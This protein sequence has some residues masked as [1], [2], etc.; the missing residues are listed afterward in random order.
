M[1]GCA[2]RLLLPVAP[3]D[4]AKRFRLRAG[5]TGQLLGV[6]FRGCRIRLLPSRFRPGLIF[7][8]KDFLPV[9]V[10]IGVH[11]LRS[12]RLRGFARTL[13]SRSLRQILAMGERRK[14]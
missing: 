4:L 5:F 11:M 10:F 6:L 8:G 13:L 1:L 9:Q 3:R 14:Q 2:R 12:F 7:W